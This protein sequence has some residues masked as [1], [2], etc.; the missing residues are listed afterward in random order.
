M[1]IDWMIEHFLNKWTTIASSKILMS[2]NLVQ[3]LKRNTAKNVLFLV[4]TNNINSL[5]TL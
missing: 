2:R 5:S 3:S 1:I 4:K